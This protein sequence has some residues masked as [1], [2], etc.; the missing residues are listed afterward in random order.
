MVIFLAATY[1]AVRSTRRPLPARPGPDGRRMD[2]PR[3]GLGGVRGRGGGGVLAGAR[4]SPQRL[5]EDIRAVKARTNRPFGVNFLL[6]PPEQGG[7]DV[8]TVQ[9]FLDGFREELG[10]APGET[11][12]SLPSSPLQEQLEVVFEEGV[13]LLSLAMGDPGELFERAHEEGVR[14]IAMVTSVKEAVLVAERGTNMVY[15][16]NYQ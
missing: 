2:H 7:G 13:P 11:A 15:P 16:P 8:A 6:A 5:Q 14:T 4:I 9:R 3:A 12:L 1:S 10:L